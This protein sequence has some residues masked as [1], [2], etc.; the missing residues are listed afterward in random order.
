MKTTDYTIFRNIVGNRKIVSKQAEKLAE[1]IERKNL[2]EYFPVLVNEHM[3]VIDGQHRLVA[4]AKLQYPV[5]Y[6]VVH[7]LKLEDVMSI[8]TNSKSWTINDFIDTYITLGNQS[9]Q[10]L[11]DFM[12]KYNMAPSMSAALLYGFNSTTPGGISELLRDGKFNV[13]TPDFA[14]KV[15]NSLNDLKRYAEFRISSDRILINTLR[16]LFNNETFDFERLLAKLRL[17]NLKL[18]KRHT[19]AQYLLEIEELYNF[20]SK[21]KVELYTS[22]QIK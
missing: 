14:Y 3:Q 8:N 4:A 9:Y 11:K 16:V 22:S 12:Q 2:L 19:T 6:E 13:N 7:G 17:S 18:E 10:V 1:A 5:H 15:A 20:N 21:I